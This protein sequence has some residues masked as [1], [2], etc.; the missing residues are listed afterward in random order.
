MCLP[1]TRFLRAGGGDSSGDWVR[2]RRLLAESPLSTGG[3]EPGEAQGDAAAKPLNNSYVK[4]HIQ[5]LR[6]LK[7]AINTSDILSLSEANS[8][9]AQW[10]FGIQER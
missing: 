5:P 9:L 4:S 6:Y 3:V 1:W 2:A 10:G 8:R 7:T